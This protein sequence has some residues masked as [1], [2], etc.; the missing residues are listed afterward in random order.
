MSTTYTTNYHL[1]KQEDTSDN[2]NMSVITDNMDIIDTALSG[3]QATLTTA[4]LS[5]VNS[6]IDSTKVAQIETNQNN[7]S[8]IQ[9]T[10]GDIN[11][12]LEEVL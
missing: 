12:V 4:Q 5:A 6:G 11:S 1:G 3:K 8:S 2:F 10:I 9:Q 7:I